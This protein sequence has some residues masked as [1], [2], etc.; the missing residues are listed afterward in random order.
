MIHKTVMMK[1][2]LIWSKECHHHRNLRTKKVTSLQDFIIER[3]PELVALK[4]NVFASLTCFQS[5]LFF[6]FLIKGFTKG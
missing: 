5:F 3:I 1:K 6:F 4:A 2:C